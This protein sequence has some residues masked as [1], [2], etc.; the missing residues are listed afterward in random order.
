MADVEH[1]HHML[2]VIDL[3]QHP[4]VAAEAGAMD[5]RQV[6]VPVTELRLPGPDGQTMEVEVPRWLDVSPRY[7]LEVVGPSIPE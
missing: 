3:I 2:G 6:G 5:A 7:G 4:P 1:D